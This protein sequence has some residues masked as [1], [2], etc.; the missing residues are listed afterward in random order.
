MITESWSLGRHNYMA[1]MLRVAPSLGHKCGYLKL[2]MCRYVYV[3][4]GGVDVK[5]MRWCYALVGARFA[6]LWMRWG[7]I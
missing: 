3:L 1:L 7:I 4:E 2:V 6:Y 5:N